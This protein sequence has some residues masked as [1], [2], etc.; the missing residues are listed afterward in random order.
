MATIKLKFRS[1]SVPHTPGTLYYQVTHNRKVKYLRTNHHVYNHEW[2]KQH[3]TLEV[4]AKGDRQ[5]LLIQMQQQLNDD[6]KQWTLLI[7]TLQRQPNLTVDALCKAFQQAKNTNTV[8]HFL[9]KQVL[10]KRQMKRYGTARTYSNALSRFKAFRQSIDLTFDEL[11]P[12]L[13]EHYEAWL[14][15][16]RLKTNTIRCYLRTLHTLL[17]KASRESL[18]SSPH[19]LFSQVRLSYVNTAKRAISEESLKAIAHLPLPPDTT[20]ALAR[21]I[22]MFSFYMRGMPFVDIAYLRKAD[23]KNGLLTYCRKK[24]NQCLTVACEEAQQTI[25]NR[26]V[27]QTR[28]TPYLLPII[29][30]DDGTE[31][32]QYQ[33]AQV[34][35]NRALK[36]IGRMVGLQIP[37]T[38]Y[39][40]RHTWASIARDM[41]LNMGLISEAMGHQSLKTT[42]VYLN[43]IDTSKVNEANKRIIERI[44]VG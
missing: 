27:H 25:I 15:N 1:S 39:V 6:L 7:T 28:S 32:I 37:L 23:L 35:V 17:Y 20:I 43:N 22:F 41:N 36:K 34:N 12:D 13:I 8:F 31:Y 19:N 9:H 42:Q 16:Q 24:T 14:I 10:K 44:Y 40:A 2:N 18:L 30:N 3:Q 29:I 26:Y 33:R 11:T 21:D 4:P 5:A 38:T